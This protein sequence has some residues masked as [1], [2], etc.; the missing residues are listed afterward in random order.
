MIIQ[1]NKINQNGLTS[2]MVAIFIIVVVSL[3]AIGFAAVARRD[4]VS[5]LDKTLSYQAQYAA[6]SGVNKVIDFINNNPTI[7]ANG[8]CNPITGFEKNFDVGEAKVTCATWSLDTD[9]IVIGASSNL[10]NFASFKGVSDIKISWNT[11]SYPNSSS[12]PPQLQSDKPV[13]GISIA[14]A[15]FIGSDGSNLNKRFYLMPQNNSGCGNQSISNQSGKVMCANISDGVASIIINGLSPDIEYYINANSLNSSNNID[16]SIEK[17]SRPGV[18]V[19]TSQYKIDVN[20]Q[21]QDVSK[22]VIAYYSKFGTPG[23]AYV[24]NVRENGIICKDIKVDGAQSTSVS[25]GVVCPNLTS[26]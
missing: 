1:K 10:A 24:V 3:L 14:P 7:D 19:N 11:N 26:L 23:P 9:K 13:I 25:G 8:D 17:G 22:R 20:S 4:Q 6:E 21:A 2:I 16:V 18:F 12:L 15:Q 5:T